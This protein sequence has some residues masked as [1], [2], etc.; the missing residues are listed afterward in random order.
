MVSLG[1]AISLQGRNNIAEQIGKMTFQATEAQK[2]RALKAGV[3]AGETAKEQQKQVMDLFKKTGDYHRLVVPKANQAIT[4]AFNKI[5][6]AK[7][8]GT[9]FSS[10]QFMEINRDLTTELNTLKAYSDALQNFDNQTKFVDRGKKYYGRNFEPFIG[11]YQK[12]KSIDELQELAKS[13][14]QLR[15][16]SYFNVGED[17][18][19]F[20]NPVEAIP[21]SKE[22]QTQAKMMKPIFVKNSVEA[23]S[24]AYGVRLIKNTSVIPFTRDDLKAILTKNP[25]L[26]D[27]SPMSIED[28]V[29]N[30]MTDNFRALEQIADRS[31]VEY[32]VDKDGVPEQETIDGIKQV[33]M[34]QLKPFASVKQTNMPA[35]PQRSS[36]TTGGGSGPD[37]A[38]TDNDL[39]I[40]IG[41][42]E[43]T[44]QSGEKPFTYAAKATRPFSAQEVKSFRIGKSTVATQWGTLNSPAGEQDYDLESAVVLPYA[45]AS[46]NTKRPLFKG[47]TAAVAGYHPFLRFGNATNKVLVDIEKVR[48]GN[49]TNGSAVEI[50]KFDALTTRLKELAA[51]YSQQ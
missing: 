29:D 7:S 3:E 10:N 4:N 42:E 38:F 34:N 33:L 1:E 19:P 21:Y 18:I 36:S 41:I 12:A 9:P 51:S 28:M 26:K 20:V 48:P 37:G 22:L 32:V 27:L 15:Q 8:S 11:A 16:G 14:P 5:I 45:L 13:N 24:G 35:F 43:Q 50:K 46:D 47:S 31:G 39:G 40:A 2:A 25:E 49:I 23:P 30:Y 44:Y 6:Q 17:G